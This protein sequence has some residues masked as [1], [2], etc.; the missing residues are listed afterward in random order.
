[1]YSRDPPRRGAALTQLYTRP[2]QDSKH[3]LSASLPFSEHHFAEP[4]WDM[5]PAGDVN[6]EGYCGRGGT[7]TPDLTDVNRAA[8]PTNRRLHNQALRATLQ[9]TH[10]AN[11][12]PCDWLPIW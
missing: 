1:M 3:G 4:R 2:R 10:T 6:L 12:E 7:R 5:I 9:P 11:L 8:M